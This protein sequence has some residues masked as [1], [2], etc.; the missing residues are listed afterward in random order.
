MSNSVVV[1]LGRTLEEAEFWRRVFE[2]DLPDLE[3][4][5]TASTYQY[6][7]LYGMRVHKLYVAP[8]ASKGSNFTRALKV[9]ENSVARTAGS[10]ETTYLGGGMIYTLGNSDGSLT[11]EEAVA[12]LDAIDGRD[13]EGAHVEADRVLVR[14]VDP[15]VREAYDRVVDRADFWAYT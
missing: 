3:N 15:R 12:L 1:I 11:T 8:G 2:A 5:T 4:A 14:L 13:G 6:G 10:V 9:L 7:S